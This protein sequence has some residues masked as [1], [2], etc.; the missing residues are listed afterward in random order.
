MVK[1]SSAQGATDKVGACGM[2]AN[3]VHEYTDIL[4]K[5][6]PAVNLVA[7]QCYVV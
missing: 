1:L 6:D 7:L 5:W 3:L 4:E 2:F